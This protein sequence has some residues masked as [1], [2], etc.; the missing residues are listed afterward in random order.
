MLL[1]DAAFAAYIEDCDDR[2]LL[3]LA[4]NTKAWRD[5]PVLSRDSA[6]LA[7][8]EARLYP[9]YDGDKVKMT[10]WGW[11]VDGKEVRYVEPLTIPEPQS[12]WRHH[13]GRE[14]TVLQVT[15]MN[16]GHPSF[17]IYQGDNGKM[18]C[19]PLTDWHKMEPVNP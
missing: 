10:D 5:T 13:S 4:M 17:V 8:V 1:E 6:I 3:W 9:E 7:E 2:R 16:H 18:W 14:Y 19:R 12:R 15:E 11:D